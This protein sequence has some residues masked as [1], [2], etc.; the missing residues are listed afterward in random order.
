MKNKIKLL[1]YDTLLFFIMNG[2]TLGI[3]I[4]CYIMFGKVNGWMCPIL[5]CILGLIPLFIYIKL[6]KINPKLSII[7]L[8]SKNLGIFG[9][10][11]NFI[12]FLT[13]LLMLCT[14]YW[15]LTNFI[16]SQYLY[17]T[18]RIIVSLLFLIP[19]IYIISK[20]I[21]V[22]ARTSLILFYIEL[23][24]TIIII[25]G[26]IYQ[27]DI[28]NIFPIFEKGVYGTI[29]GSLSHVAYII[30]PSFILFS[31]PR[32]KIEQ[33]DKIDKNIF[34]TYLISNLN[35]FLIILL[36]ILVLGIELLDIYQYPEFHILKRVFAGGFVERME[37]LL[38]VHWLFY[39]FIFITMCFYY[40]EQYFKTVN[41]K[42]KK[43]LYLFMLII[44]YL[45]LKTFKN[46]T[47]ANILTLNYGFILFFPLLVIPISI[48]IIIKFR[49]NKSH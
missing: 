45:S 31:I 4:N 46:N 28:N 27:I 3:T 36:N 40:I 11:I 6:S 15:N 13:V 39:L 35:V 12:L 47:L 7:Q 14:V 23:M 37:A 22:I 16:T 10:I 29:C 42:S 2:M 41:I 19:F 33:Q 43:I 34:I 32:D 44:M 25:I 38:S 30:L 8:I 49:Q 26:L 48:L 17:N 9:K 18:P 21:E 1:E 20:G 5:G 24:L